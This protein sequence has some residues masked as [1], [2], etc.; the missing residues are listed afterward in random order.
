PVG[1][2]RRRWRP[3]GPWPPT[4]GRWRGP[5]GV[6]MG[7]H[8]GEGILGGDNYLGL[9]VHRA[10]R[11]AAAGHGGQGLVSGA[12][13]GLV[14]NALPQG[15]SLRDL[16]RHRLRDL[17]VAEH[18]YDLVIEG[19]P[20]EFPPPRP[21]GTTPRNL[22]V[23]LT[24][25]VGRDEEVAEVERLLDRARLVTLTGPGGV[26]K[27][28]LALAVA[29]RVRG[30]LDAGVGFVSLVGG[31]RPEQVLAATTGAG[32]GGK[33]RL[34]L[35]VAERV[36]GRLDAGVVFVPLVGVTRPEQVLAAI[37]RATG[38]D[39]GRRTR[40]WRPWPSSSATAAGCCCWTTSSRCSRWPMTCRGCWPAA[41]VW[42]SWRP[43]R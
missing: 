20:A 11:I 5:L 26:G 42:R 10:A 36:R 25:F 18:L 16:G 41:A 14:A 9:D 19:L 22:P 7:P 31:T 33:T 8:T 2:S 30:P 4:P 43:A 39:L 29:E 21:L 35:A 6:R 1:R 34:A 17:A 27:T 37:T 38:A 12:T 28:R 3:S 13:R 32:G 23:Q 40:R 15:V 24:S